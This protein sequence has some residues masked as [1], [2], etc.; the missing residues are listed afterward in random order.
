MWRTIT[1]ALL[2]LCVATAVPAAGGSELGVALDVS[3]ATTLPGIP[4]A[5]RVTFTNSGSTPVFLPPHLVLLARINGSD[6]FVVRFGGFRT[7]TDLRALRDDPIPPHE[8][9]V[10]EARTE[11]VLTEPG[12]L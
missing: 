11:G 12:W 4:V 7:K 10:I 8:T 9:A 6:P 3:P 2:T 5:L 1:L